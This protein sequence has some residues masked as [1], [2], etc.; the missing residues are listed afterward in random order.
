MPA[1]TE[2]GQDWPNQRSLAQHQRMSHSMLSQ[3]DSALYRRSLPADYVPRKHPV[4]G[5]WEAPT[6]GWLSLLTAIVEQAVHDATHDQVA[7]Q[8]VASITP[9]PQ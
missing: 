5:C 7:R 1:C 3:S 6:P 9:T 8:W 4:R 2:C